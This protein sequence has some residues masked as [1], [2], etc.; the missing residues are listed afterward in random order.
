MF[1]YPMEVV[2]VFGYRS[3]HEY[4]V[5]NDKDDEGGRFNIDPHSSDGCNMDHGR[6]WKEVRSRPGGAEGNFSRKAGQDGTV[7]KST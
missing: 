1:A 2:R 7:L 4:A 5:I 6:G 3:R